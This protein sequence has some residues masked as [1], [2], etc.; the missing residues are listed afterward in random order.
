[1]ISNFQDFERISLGKTHPKWQTSRYAMNKYVF[2]P[3]SKIF[4]ELFEKEKQRILAHTKTALRIEHIGST[5]VPNLGGKGIID[6][7]IAVDKG[8]M[9]LTSKHLQ[10]LGYEYRP[11]FST[12]D[13]FY[14]IIYLP[15]P[16]EEN[17]RYHIHL[18]YPENKEWKEFIDFRDYLRNHP[19]ELLDY[20]ELKKQ[21]AFEANHEGDRYRKIKEPMFKKIRSLA[22]EEVK[23]LLIRP[24][25]ESDIEKIVSRYSFPWSSPE[26]TQ[27][28]WAAYYR[29][30]Q[31]GMRT[32]A[33]LEKNHEILGYG[34]LLR[35]PEC[36]FFGENNIPEINAIWIDEK[37]R[38][39]GLGKAL[40][41]WLEDLAIQEGYD[42]IGIGV[43]LYRDYG[44]AQKLYF[45]LGYTPDGNG[46]TYKG[47]PVV[48]GQVY[49]VDDDLILW[50]MK[51]L[52]INTIH[53]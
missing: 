29:E 47:Q 52:R 3:Y 26:K 48:P 14:F 23:N 33:L 4:P 11:A 40:V 39:K 42:Q 7:A 35:K 10:D 21:A 19:Q 13:R 41:R 36:P 18:T 45:Q 37:N 43:G 44:P 1:M 49:P 20:A 32:V 8:N 16:E 28:L 9:E 51:T 6:I 38:R 53:G 34:S 24:M 27:T 15:D 30:Q 25:N 12:P 17:R 31:D 22:E 2:K 50:L 5:A 46:I